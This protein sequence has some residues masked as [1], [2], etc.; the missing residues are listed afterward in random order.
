MSSSTTIHSVTEADIGPSTTAIINA[1]Q[2]EFLE[3][4]ISQL[5]G[6]MVTIKMIQKLMLAVD[7]NALTARLEEP[8]KEQWAGS[9]S[10]APMLVKSALRSHHVL[11]LLRSHSTSASVR[12]LS[13]R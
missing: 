5:F 11:L 10:P 9:S 7:P 3:N 8:Q 4:A 2:T 6:R 1:S 12:M 13:S